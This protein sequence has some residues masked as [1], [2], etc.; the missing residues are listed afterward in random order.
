MVTAYRQESDNVSPLAKNE[1]IR[2]LQ[3]YVEEF[4]R[5]MPPFE[6]GQQRGMAVRTKVTLPIT[7]KLNWHS[8]NLLPTFYY[9]PKKTDSPNYTLIV[10]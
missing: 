10:T 7:F 2:A 1:A 9:P 3:K 5:S 8:P 6:P 4:I